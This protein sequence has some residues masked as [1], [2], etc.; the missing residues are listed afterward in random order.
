MNKLPVIYMLTRLLGVE[1]RGG[2]HHLLDC[3]YDRLCEGINQW[4]QDF[5]RVCPTE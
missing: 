1:G 4:F 2:V 3:A 5:I